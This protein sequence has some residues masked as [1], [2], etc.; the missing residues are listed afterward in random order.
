MSLTDRKPD[1]DRTER[2]GREA[3][4]W[5]TARLHF[6]LHHNWLDQDECATCLSEAETPDFN[7]EG[8]PTRNG[9]FG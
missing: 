7:F 2:S 1:E 9:A 4:E 6:N 5:A 8:D 3:A